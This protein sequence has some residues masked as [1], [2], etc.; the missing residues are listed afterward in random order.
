MNALVMYDHQTETLWSQFLR[1]GVKGELSGVKLEVVPVTQTSWSAWRELHPDTLVLDKRGGYRSD[2]YTSYYLN[3]SAGV[4]G[5]TFDDERLDRK[6]L[7]LGLDVDGRTKAY[8]FSA[9]N[10][11][12]VVNDSLGGRQVLVF[13]D[14]STGTSLV[15]DRV[16]DGKTLTFQ[17]DFEGSGAQAIITDTETGSKWMALTGMAVEGEMSGSTMGRMLSHL[18]FWFAWKDW[19]P[20]TELYGG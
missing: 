8:P 1:K 19:N 16:V 11:M 10:G 12:P 3:R 4:L 7:V 15:F 6:E 13:H 20:K 5:E 2:S 17:S 14:S 9:L 18:S